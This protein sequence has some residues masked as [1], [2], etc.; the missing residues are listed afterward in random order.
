MYMLMVALYESL[1]TPLAIMFSLPVG[2][3]G[4]CLGLYVTGT[5][6]N[7]FSLIGTI[8]LMGLIGKNA[9][10]LPACT[11]QPGRRPRATCQVRAAGAG[12]GWWASHARPRPPNRKPIHE[13]GSLF[14]R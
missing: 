11:S 1:L 9:I 2:L 4:A 10:L 12:S 8:M 13:R 14:A 6:F 5:T 7:I 3:V